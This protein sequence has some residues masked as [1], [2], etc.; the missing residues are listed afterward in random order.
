[1]FLVAYVCVF[2][3]L[4]VCDAL[5]LESLD[6]KRSYLLCKYIYRISRTSSYMKVI[7]VKVTETRKCM[8][9]LFMDDLLSIKRQHC[10]LSY[11]VAPKSFNEF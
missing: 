10:F 7:G 1:M 9:I 8:C 3:C 6:L 4:R 5:T 2:A 11:K